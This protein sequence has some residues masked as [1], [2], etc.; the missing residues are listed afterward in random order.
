MNKALKIFIGL[1]L[2]IIPLYLIFPG[3]TLA[4][5]GVAALELIKAGITI[6]VI[7][8]G[9]VLIIMGISELKN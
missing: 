2:V 6:L 5:W 8:L 3:N 1:V 9:L 4:S 7:L